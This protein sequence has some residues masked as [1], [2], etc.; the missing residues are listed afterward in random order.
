MSEMRFVNIL[1]V[2]DGLKEKVRQWRNKDEI[3]KSMLTQHIISKG[4]HAGWLKKLKTADDSKFW[5]VFV[6]DTLIG[7]AYLQNI[8][9]KKSTSEW[10][11]YIGEDA[12]KGKGLGKS[13]LFKL[14]DKAFGEMNL[15][16]LFTKVLSDNTIAFHIYEELRFKEAGRTPFKDDKEVILLQFR[17]EDWQKLKEEIEGSRCYQNQK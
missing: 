6:E 1:E 4:E 15:E 11:F 12:Y 16:I 2:D 5:V 9:R 17:R 7:V 10:G 8:D 14:L 3:R 13:I